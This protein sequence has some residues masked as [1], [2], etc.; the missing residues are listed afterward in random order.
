MQLWADP[1]LVR[2]LTDAAW[3]ERSTKSEL[4]RRILREWLLAHGHLPAAADPEP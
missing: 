3:S 4:I 2:A 1:D